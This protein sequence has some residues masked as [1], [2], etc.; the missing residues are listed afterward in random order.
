MYRELLKKYKEQYGFKLFAYGLFPG[1]VNLLVELKEGETLSMLMHDLS[2]SYTKYYNGRYARKGHLF[3][4]RFKSVVVEKE[5][6]LMQV[7]HYIHTSPVRQG[8][9]RE[10][11]EYFSSSALAYACASDSAL[12]ERNAGYLG[13]Q[14]VDIG[15]EIA[16]A[17]GVAR[18]AGASAGGYADL[19]SAVTRQEL[20]A[21]AKK[22]TSEAILGSGAFVGS[23]EQEIENRDAQ[24]RVSQWSM[25]PAFSF[26]LLVVLSGAVS[27]VLYYQ[28]PQPAVP[29]SPVVII[30]NEAPLTEELKDIDAT[31][32]I[33]E[34]VPDKGTRGAYPRYDKITFLNNTVRSDYFLT[35]GFVPSNYSAHLQE[36]GLLVWETMQRNPK[37]DV[38]FWRGEVK[39]G[40][41]RGVFRKKF[42]DGNSEGVTFKSPGYYRVAK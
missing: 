33:T 25:S 17:L 38:I 23:I 19:L 27:G 4:E 22:L 13:A 37:G 32:W 1:S 20:D 24:E 39:Q 5:P 7:I 21:L 30:K 2:S 9:A 42:A 40:G 36:D 10:P 18:L 12:K 3:R 26:S 29:S 31:E 14:L 41:M 6:Y 11:F 8:L 35:E 16:E 28:K 15:S 34:L